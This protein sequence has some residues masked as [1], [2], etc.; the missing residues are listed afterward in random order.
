[1]G[2]IYDLISRCYEIMII[3]ILKLGIIRIVLFNFWFL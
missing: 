3:Y 1:M 2:Y